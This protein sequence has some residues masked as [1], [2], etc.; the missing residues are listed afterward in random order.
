MQDFHSNAI[1]ADI[2]FDVLVLGL[3]AFVL[4]LWFEW[5]DGRRRKAFA[6]ANEQIAIDARF[7]ELSTD[8]ALTI[9]FA[10]NIIS[11]NRAWEDQLG[12]NLKILRNEAFGARIHPDDLG[13]IGGAFADVA[14]GAIE[15][16]PTALRFKHMDGSWRWLEWAVSVSQADELVFA[17][18]RDVTDRVELQQALDIERQQLRSAQDIA[19]I[20]S[21]HLELAT[22]E[23]FW[24]DAT[25]EL[26]GIE[27]PEGLPDAELWLS[28]LDPSEHERG[29][30]R[31]ADAIV[32][33]GDFSFDF[34]R[35]QL[36]GYGE[37]V[38]IATKGFAERGPDGRT[39]RLIGTLVDI[40]ERKR[41]Q[42]G[43]KFI[44]DHDP[45]TSL[46]NRRKFDEVLA[47][48]VSDCERY[49]PS[50][51]VLMLD[52]D[53]LKQVNDGFG[54]VAGDNMIRCM[55]DALRDRLRDTDTGARIG[56]DEFAVLLTRTTH[57]GA[58]MVAR[59]I[60]ERLAAGSPE[61][62]SIGVQ[63]ITASI[64]IVLVRDLEK[65]SSE[66]L[67]TAADDAMYAAKRAGLGKVREYLPHTNEPDFSG[68]TALRQ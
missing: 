1:V 68:L 27:P 42:D 11:C 41:Y 4:S 30:A 65:I 63:E 62:Q 12:L 60:G 38:F 31:L 2:A 6:Q 58:R 45:L 44:A 16:E 34:Q 7:F 54:H 23:M 48:H 35:A 57:E 64:G 20:G 29:Q 8:L 10:G 19:R 39:K 61:L 32:N 56:G 40:T 9:D 59:S 21:W 43:L 46:S 52:L 67:M 47:R 28:S 36:D 24:S 13:D 15:T 26:L 22:G 66:R 37:P 53:K 33:G 3:I 5:R 55:A 25:Y 50:G 17:T 18:A 49:G 14:A 51:A